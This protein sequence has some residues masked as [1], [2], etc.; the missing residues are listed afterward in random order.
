MRAEL[1]GEDTAGLHVDL[2][3]SR[4]ELDDPGFAVLLVAKV[5]G[6]CGPSEEPL[7][8][9][10]AAEEEVSPLG[11]GTIAEFMSLVEAARAAGV[12]VDEA[13][14]DAEAREDFVG[15]RQQLKYRAM[16][17]GDWSYQDQD[18]EAAWGQMLARTRDLMCGEKY[19]D[20][21]IAE[22]GMGVSGAELEAEAEAV[23]ARQGTTV[24]Q[25]RM[26]LGSG[27][28]GLRRDLLRKKAM[29]LVVGGH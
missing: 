7:P 20:Q 29:E 27:F 16:A 23:A 26:F 5:L 6:C 2:T 3:F 25:L 22:K 8:Q 19:L 9:G 14:V 11:F 15:W 28:E 17:T 18:Q 24:A 13:Q 12:T 21:V 10:K 1:A 4:E